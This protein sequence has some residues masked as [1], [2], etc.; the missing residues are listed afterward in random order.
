[1]SGSVFSGIG[2]SIFKLGFEISPIMFT[3]GIANFMG[4]AMP[5]IMVTESA[6]LI[7]GLLAGSDVTDL[8]QFFAHFTP[9]AGGK[10]ASYT[11]GTY[12]FA[13]QQVAANAIITQ[14]LT[15][16][17]RM[18]IPVNKPGGHTAKLV[19]MMMLKSLIDK[20]ANLG[21]TYTVATPAY[22]YT[23]CLLTGL[24]DVSQSGGT[25]PIPQ[26]TWQFDFVQPLI[27]LQAAQAAQNTFMSKLTAGTPTDGSLNAPA[28]TVGS[29]VPSV[30]SPTNA[31]S[32]GVAPGAQGGQP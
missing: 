10:L 21:G 2:R 6:N 23:N 30:T 27:T 3:N 29:Q 15:F 25:S 28:A 19:T 7:T 8:D 17:M 20:H 26:N 1:M 13:N 22:I 12:P 14:P 9:I 32:L 16:S 5:I 18:V 4:G 31:T 11:V 24:T